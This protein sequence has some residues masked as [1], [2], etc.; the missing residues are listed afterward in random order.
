MLRSI[1]LG[2]MLWALPGLADERASR[3]RVSANGDFS[4]RLVERGPGQCSLEVSQESGP[5]W[6]LEQ[7]VGGADDLYFVSNDGQR[8]W[9][10][11][12]LAPKGQKK[13]AG[14]KYKKVPAWANTQVAVEV[15][16]K[17][18][19]LQE[20]R[21]LEFVP[22]RALPQVRQMSQ[23]IKWLEGMVGVP[24]RSPRL[25]DAG[26]IEFEVVG[27]DKTHRLTF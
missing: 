6:T 15:D 11:Y 20:R 9:V 18:T 26:N 8:V 1:C 21:L 5:V 14:R 25:T 27:G 13:L 16:R 7:C 19:R 23:H 3:P 10:V 12:P 2:M 17:G 24:G 4:V 22:T